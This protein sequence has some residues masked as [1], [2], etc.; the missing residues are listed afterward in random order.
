MNCRYN[1][2]MN[3]FLQLFLICAG[4][5]IVSFTQNLDS[6]PIRLKHRLEVS[7]PEDR[8]LYASFNSDG[9]KV[10]LVNKNSTQIWSA[11]TG[12]LV[13]SFP[14]KIPE[15]YGSGFEWQ[16]NGSKV[17]QTGARGEKAAAYIWDAETGR[18]TGVINEKKGIAYAEWNKTGD[19]ILAVGN[20]GGNYSLYDVPIS[21]RDQNG[22]VIR[23]EFVIRPSSTPRASFTSDGNNVIT[24]SDD[25]YLDGRPVRISDAETGETIKAFDQELSK[26]GF[27]SFSA[28]SPDGKFICGQIIVS[29]G[30]VCW[31]TEG[32]ESPIYYFLD[33]KETGDI[34]FLN[35]SPDSKSFAI[36]K[37]KKN[38]IEIIDTETGKVKSTLQNP[39]KARLILFHPGMPLTSG[40]S[41]SPDSKAF[42]ASNFEKE[43]SMWNTHTGELVAKLPLIYDD[44]YDWF[45]G[46]L[47]TDYERFSFHPSG[48]ILLSI[49]RLSVKLWKPQT[50][51]LLMEVKEPVNKK[52]PGIYQFSVAQ[53]SSDGNL[54][55][56][57]GEENKSVLLWEVF[58][59]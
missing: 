29:K 12:K 23:T 24:S 44:D 58:L 19:K 46:T 36:L 49:G 2:R 17:L 25:R 45:V 55:I 30:V 9:T 6:K 20:T 51:E 39:N 15:K 11:E 14:E 38:V 7:S 3:W 10:L 13:L 18:L 40:D 21:I 50:G 31:K 53:W 56:T 5:P 57:A 26:S 59:K 32:T 16:P 47:V 52:S 43:A 37:P 34:S 42:I 41:W 35:F 28:E 33:T 27:A 8:V 48:K 22:K 1:S 54:L 4:F